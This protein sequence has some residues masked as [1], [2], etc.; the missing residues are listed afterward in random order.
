MAP[1]T[2][3]S[4][5]TCILLCSTSFSAL[6]FFRHQTGL[7]PL[8]V[9]MVTRGD[10]RG[11]GEAIVVLPNQY[12]MQM[13]LS[14]D[15][16]HMGRRCVRFVFAVVVETSFA[17]DRRCTLVLLWLLRQAARRTAGALRCR[18]V[19]RSSWLR[20][21]PSR[22][23]LFQAPWEAHQKAVC[24]RDACIQAAAA[25]NVCSASI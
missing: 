4:P 10:G 17:E 2:R 24:E 8:D 23:V 15:K 11:A 7:V 9:V 19:R 5:S 6:P 20:L 18:G 1:L 3:L 14:R 16:Q 13:A 22:L 25:Y 21:L 12:E